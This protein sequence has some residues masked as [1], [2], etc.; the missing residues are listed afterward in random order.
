MNVKDLLPGQKVFWKREQN[1][2]DPNAIALYADEQMT[3]SLGHI[4]RK[5]AAWLVSRLDEKK[6]FVIYVTQRTG[7]DG[8]NYG[9]NI[10]VQIW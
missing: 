9:V 5:F 7:G 4:S 6:D 10:K 3:A 8:K 1:P 2:H